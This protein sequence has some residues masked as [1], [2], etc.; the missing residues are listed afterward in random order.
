MYAEQRFPQPADAGAPHWSLGRR[1]AFRFFAPYLVL[2]HLDW[3]LGQFGRTV[4]QTLYRQPM[5]ALDGWIGTTFFGL[6][7]SDLNLRWGGATDVPLFYIHVLVLLLCSALIAIA[8]SLLDRRRLEY[9]SLHAWM[10]LLVRYSL[11]ANLFVYGFAKV[12]VGQMA[13]ASMFV[14]RLV[15]RFG[16]MSPAG[17]L[18]AFV[19][20]SPAYQIFGGLAEVLAASLLLFRRTTTLGALIAIGVM[21]NVVMLN[22]G[23]QV[24]VK[25]PSMNLL[26]AAVFLAAP[27]LGKLTR[28]FVFNQRADAPDASDP[29]LERR[30]PRLALTA[31]KVVVATLMLY[32]SIASGYRNSLF[33]PPSNRPVL[34]GL[35]EVETFIQN[36]DERP[37]LTTDPARWKT[38]TIGDPSTIMTVQMMD[39][40]LRHHN[41]EY[42]TQG[43][44]VTLFTG[45]DKKKR[46]TLQCSRPDQDHLVMEGR[47]GDDALTVRMKRIDLSTFDLLSMPFRWTGRT[48]IH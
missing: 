11:A 16:D 37:P 12:F 28:F 15:E 40:S 6:K 7:P 46:Y 39:A 4:R 26:L 41:A 3:L 48:D 43:N 33:Q 18:W 20:Y 32:N 36:G 13:P 8:W 35:Y 1:F 17:L 5:I 38:V 31:C 21:L 2:Y 25:L 30:L 9:Q 10:R 19:G 22:F 24:A 23:Y 27:D 29:R 34:S 14:E 42:D 44:S 47:F 45:N